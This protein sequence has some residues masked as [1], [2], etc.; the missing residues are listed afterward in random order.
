MS[1]WPNKHLQ[2]RTHLTRTSNYG[3][4][5]CAGAFTLIELL[6]V[7]AI[8]ALLVSILLPSLEE[9]RELARSAAC[10]SNLK[11][12]RL[13][14]WLYSEDNDGWLCPALIDYVC[15]PC[16]LCESGY[17]PKEKGTAIEINAAPPWGVLQCPSET[18]VMKDVGSEDGLDRACDPDTGYA[19]KGSNYGANRYIVWGYTPLIKLSNVTALFDTYLVGDARGS[20]GASIGPINPLRLPKLRHNGI[21]NVVYCDGHV[22]GLNDFPKDASSSPWQP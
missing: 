12:V 6:V 8:I 19:W 7:V 20:G 3:N 17:L 1:A 22:E 11:Q 21:W 18:Y 16:L 13:A 10:K 5:L 15:W 4:R 14:M 9:A 2:K